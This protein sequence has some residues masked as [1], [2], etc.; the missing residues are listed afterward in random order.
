MFP[1]TSFDYRRPGEREIRCESEEFAPDFVA[2]SAN[3]ASLQLGAGL[4]QN[5]ARH[6]ELLDLLGAF[7]DVP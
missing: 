1:D 7:E 6:D 5:A 2:H 3:A 4:A